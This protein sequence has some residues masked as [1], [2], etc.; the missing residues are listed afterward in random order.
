MKRSTLNFVIDAL[1]FALF[2]FLTATGFVLRYALPAGS[3]RISGGGQ[4]YGAMARDITVL[5]GLDRHQWGEIHFT[6]SVFILILLS[7]HL[8]LH[9]RWILAV[10]R[11][12]KREG[13]GARVALGA[14]GILGLL[15]LAISPF[16][17]SPE[18]F[19]RNEL[20]SGLSAEA[21]TE[22][23]A[24]SHDDSIRGNMTLQ[25]IENETGVS[26]QELI[27]H[28]G[29]PPETPVQE[30]MGRLRKQYGFT[31]EQVREAVDELQKSD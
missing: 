4:G 27:R 18:Q 2:L 3:G 29:M 10:V 11:G 7:L 30:K 12:K 14:M 23:L 19:T 1:T 20:K 9:W 16:F 24:P 17:S 15:F 21:Q 6:I 22:A 25:E 31:M 26:A 28:L 8:V 5:W 13:S